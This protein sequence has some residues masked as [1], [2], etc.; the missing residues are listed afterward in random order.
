M[1]VGSRRIF[2]AGRDT[3]FRRK[4]L[5]I[6]VTEIR[7]GFVATA[8]AQSPNLFWVASVETAAKQILNAVNKRS[9]QVYV[10]KRWALIAVLLRVFPN[11]L[12]NKI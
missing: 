5:P 9:E 11:I 6:Y 1:F 7:P 8:M 3:R 10:T 2:L 12:Y 4:G